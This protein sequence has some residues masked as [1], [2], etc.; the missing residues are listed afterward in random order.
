M[1]MVQYPS[2]KSSRKK[3][4]SFTSFG[5][6]Q[7]GW[8]KTYQK[9]IQENFPLLSIQWDWA[10]RQNSQHTLFFLSDSKRRS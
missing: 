8:G 3:T 2:K 5:G 7:G 6:G 10:S 9:M 4:D 1:N